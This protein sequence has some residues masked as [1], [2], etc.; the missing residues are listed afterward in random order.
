ML[1]LLGIA[2][3]GGRAAGRV[4][5]YF[6]A[7]NEKVL[8]LRSETMPFMSS[9]DVYVPYTMFD[10][11]S[12]GINLGVYALYGSS[13]AMVYDRSSRMLVFDLA[14]NTTETADGTLLS[15]TA[16]R[17]NSM[18]F[19]PV[20]LVCSYFDLDWNMPVDPDYGFIVRVKNSAV[21]LSDDEF[22]AA[23][24]YVMTVR[25]NDYVRSITGGEPKPSGPEPSVPSALPSPSPAPTATHT[26]APSVPGVS[27]PPTPQG[28]TVYLAFSCDSGGSTADLASAL[29][30]RGIFGLFFFRPEDLTVRDDEVRS[31]AAAGHKIGLLLDGSDEAARQEQARYGNELL[32]HIL[33]SSAS[34][35]LTEAGQLP[36]AGWFR[37]TTDVDGRAQDRTANERLQSIIQEA[38]GPQECFLL[39]DDSSQTAGLLSRLLRNLEDNGC[40][41]RLA[42]ETVL[43]QQYGAPGDEDSGGISP[44][45]M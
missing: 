26:P 39:L 18:V 27:P 40:Q 28:G 32:G 41:F 34:I 23:A 11:N 13:T 22:A 37:W 19:L 1:L 25:Y 31:L 2:M 17:R 43:P 36:P 6:M 20:N 30:R 24:K 9:G 8:E 3:A 35:A 38:V 16:I 45:R 5:V 12:T 29:E 4:T 21:Q 44:F 7:V 15:Q 10:P 33:R 14:A 42:L